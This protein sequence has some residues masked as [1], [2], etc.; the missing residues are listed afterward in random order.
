MFQVSSGQYTCQIKGSLYKYVISSFTCSGF[1]WPVYFSTWVTWEFLL[2][3]VYSLWKHLYWV[4][5]TLW[6]CFVFVSFVYFVCIVCILLWKPLYLA[7]LIWMEC[8]NYLK[9]LCKTFSRLYV[10]SSCVYLVFSRPRY[11]TTLVAQHC[12]ILHCRSVNDPRSECYL[13]CLH[14]Q[15]TKLNGLFRI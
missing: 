11:F 12:N 13:K 2:P 4:Y 5:S 15:H 10:F 8:S 1:K 3:S 9:C 6:T 7:S 14:F